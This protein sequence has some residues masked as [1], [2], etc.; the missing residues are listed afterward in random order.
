MVGG[1]CLRTFIIGV[2]ESNI[3]R[4]RFMYNYVQTCCSY[5]DENHQL[6]QWPAHIMSP[7]CPHTHLPN[8]RDMDI[9][10][11]HTRQSSQCS[12]RC[13]KSSILHV[14]YSMWLWYHGTMVGGTMV[15]GTM[16]PRSMVPTEKS[17]LINFQF[18]NR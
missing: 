17:I 16:V 14:E 15:V 4:N 6:N 5:N 10:S 7:T 12:R 13:P 1:D 18:S 8:T 11:Q 3:D 2:G 9:E